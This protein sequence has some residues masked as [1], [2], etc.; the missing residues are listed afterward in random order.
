GKNRRRAIL[1]ALGVLGLGLLVGLA[2]ERLALNAFGSG[3]NFSL[4]PFRILVVDLLNALSLGLSVDLARV[5][6]LDYGFAAVAL[7]GA[8]WPLRNRRAI[9]REAW[10][11]PAFVILPV[12]ELD[13][14]Q[15]IQPAYMNARHMSLISAAFVLLLAAG[16]AAVWQQ[17]RWAGAL[18]GGVL[19]AGM[20]YSTVN[21][22]SVADYARDNFA[23][24]GADLAAEM[25]PGDGIVLVPAQMIRLYQHYLPLDAIESDNLTSTGSPAP[26][27]RGW[28]ALPEYD[29]PFETTIAR[30]QQMLQK[31][32]RVWLVVSGMVPLSPYQDETR[33]W[34]ASHGFLA[35][36]L[37]YRS[38]TFLWLKL[39]LPQP[40]ILPELP[41]SVEH[42]VTAVF[43]D[44]IR[45]DGYD[46][47]KPLTSTSPTPVTLYWQPLEKLERRYK[48]ILRLVSVADDGSL[49]TLAQT[50]LEP[51]SGS[52][53]TTWWSPGPEIFEY[54]QL[55]QS[56]PFDGPRASL[57]LAIELY[58]A[59][60]LEKLPVTR[61]PEGGVLTD[62]FTFLMPFED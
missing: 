28:A 50:D 17:R 9:P 19:V 12:V 8:L 52:L 4:V 49:H 57:R 48:Y 33:E 16:C 35:R 62:Q 1:T 18:V 30:L 61:T 45:L 46:I 43:G 24:V 31:H 54:S 47:G 42:R 38:N 13:I 10:L 3:S 55:P 41:A 58:D 32:R 37:K 60:T 15:H 26:P 25:Q 40:P 53:P 14:I 27:L 6:W 56:A 23:E 22:F 44:K 5:R 39:Y 11:L 21:Y 36:D 7:L 20:A 2:A 29:E 59:E 34:L 51:Y